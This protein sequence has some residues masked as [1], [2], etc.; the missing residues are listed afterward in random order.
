MNTSRKWSVFFLSEPE[1]HEKGPEMGSLVLLF[2][3]VRIAGFEPALSWSRTKH[4]TKLSYILNFRLLSH[5][6]IHSEKVQAEKLG[7]QSTAQEARIRMRQRNS[8]DRRTSGKICL[9]PAEV[10]LNAE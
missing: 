5:V 4:F 1:K 2:Q 6:N 7:D 3:M 9:S 10:C 8:L